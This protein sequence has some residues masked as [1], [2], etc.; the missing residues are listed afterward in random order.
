[1]PSA[2]LTAADFLHIHLQTSLKEVGRIGCSAH[3]TQRTD[4]KLPVLP[5]PSSLK[6]LAGR[7]SSSLNPQRKYFFVGWNNS[8]PFSVSLWHSCRGQDG[9]GLGQIRHI[10]DA[11]HVQGA[12][13]GGF[14][15]SCCKE[16]G[17]SSFFSSLPWLGGAVTCR[18]EGWTS[19]RWTLPGHIL[20]FPMRCFLVYMQRRILVCVNKTEIISSKTILGSFVWQRAHITNVQFRS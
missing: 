9:M 12:T 16:W 13:S 8:A 1:M 14:A 18:K 3:H 10:P 6:A 17:H 11:E 20:F 5:F 15:V 19:G 4:G 2:L 7:A